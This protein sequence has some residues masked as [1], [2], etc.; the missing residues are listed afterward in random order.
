[1]LKALHSTQALAALTTIAL[2]FPITI[3]SVW[4]QT[5]QQQNIQDTQIIFNDP[6]PPD[7]GSPSG[8]QRGGSS[9]G[10]CRQFES[11]A[12]LVPVT[13]GVVLGKTVSDRPAFWFYLPQPLTEQTPIEFVI[14]D[15]AD[16][17]VYS[18][19]QTAPNTKPGLIRL[20]VPA[21]AQALKIGQSYTW[22]LS[23]YCDPDKPSSAVFV[24]GMIQRTT[25][26]EI[27]QNRFK[28]LSP[29]EQT[30]LYAANDIWFDAF[31]TLATLYS[32]QPNDR[33][34]N[35]IWQTLLKQADL[36]DLTTAPFSACCMLKQ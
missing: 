11:L 33:Q 19:R 14:Q 34:L 12:A 23:V 26:D 25:S 27:S 18:T 10:P 21:D 3:Q 28:M 13:N 6:T 20:Q 31:N 1:M 17:E 24:Q 8:R 16:N 15:A 35:S 5:P 7:K 4:A 22:T 2:T 30:R 29:L 9:R 36:A 32:Q